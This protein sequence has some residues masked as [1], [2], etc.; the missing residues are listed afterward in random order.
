MYECEEQMEIDSLLNSFGVSTE[1][2]SQT[3]VM[4]QPKVN[5]S[6]IFLLYNAY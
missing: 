1:S 5:C 6:A 4:F 2:L 3:Y